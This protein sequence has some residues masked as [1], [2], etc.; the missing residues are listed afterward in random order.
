MNT[1][2]QS[3]TIKKKKKNSGYMQTPGW[4][5]TDITLMKASKCKTAHT[6]WV[7]SHKVEKKQNELIVR[8]PSGQI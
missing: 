7:H 2:G 8:R 6:G 3:T 4:I 5:T 1:M